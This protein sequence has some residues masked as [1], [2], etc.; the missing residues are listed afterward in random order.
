MRSV[1][2]AAA[3]HRAR[4]EHAYTGG[5]RHRCLSGEPFTGSAISHRPAAR[6]LDAHQGRLLSRWEVPNPDGRG[7]SLR[8]APGVGIVRWLEVPPDRLAQTDLIK[9]GDGPA[10][11]HY[12]ASNA[13]MPARHR[14]F[15]A[16]AVASLVNDSSWI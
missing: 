1:S 16:S 7:E 13:G 6:S 9:F 10:F 2:C 15:V 5:D 12:A 3:L 11:R 4:P 14:R 8:R